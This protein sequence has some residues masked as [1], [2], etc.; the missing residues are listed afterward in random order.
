MW[1]MHNTEMDTDQAYD[2]A[3][4]EFYALRQEEEIERRLA[5]EEAR[6]VGAYFGKNKLQIGQDL[7]DKEFETWKGWAG[8]RATELEQERNAS[9]TTFGESSDEKVDEAADLELLAEQDGTTP[10]P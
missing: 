9:Y 1:L 4:K 10:A 3:R 7:E 5:R 2:V 6:Y 8:K